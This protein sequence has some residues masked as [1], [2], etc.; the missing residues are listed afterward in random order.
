[1]NSKK[2]RELPA[3]RVSAMFRRKANFSTDFLVNVNRIL[4]IVTAYGVSMKKHDY[5]SFLHTLVAF[6]DELISLAIL[7]TFCLCGADMGEFKSSPTRESWR[8][9]NHITFD[10]SE[11]NINLAFNML[12]KCNTLALHLDNVFFPS[13]K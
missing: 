5:V 13:N 8:S 10:F 9:H 6:V 2:A 1:M 4:P 7:Y 12:F 11:N 3:V